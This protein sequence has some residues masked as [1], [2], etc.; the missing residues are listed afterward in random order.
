VYP[1]QTPFD[2]SEIYEN[3]ALNG[4]LIGYELLKRFYEIGSLNGIKDLSNY[5][6]SQKK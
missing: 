3:L 5:L 2:L 6:N 1:D 4:E